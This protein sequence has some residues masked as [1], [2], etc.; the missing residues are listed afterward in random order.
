MPAA[1]LSHI[2]ASAPGPPSTMALATPT[3]VP[4]PTVAARLV[5]SA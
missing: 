3:M 2:Q 1:A 5:I 4:V